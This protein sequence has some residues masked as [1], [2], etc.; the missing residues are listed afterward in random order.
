MLQILT[1][2]LKDYLEQKKE[3]DA[4]CLNLMKEGK[5]WKE[6][7]KQGVMLISMIEV[8]LCEISKYEKSTI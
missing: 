6:V 2:Q 5:E 4:K 3:I 7:A 8:T 1:E